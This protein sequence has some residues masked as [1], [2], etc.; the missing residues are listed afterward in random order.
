MNTLAAPSASTIIT[1]AK[2]MSSWSEVIG[3]LAELGSDR[4]LRRNCRRGQAE[5]GERQGEH[6][7]KREFDH[8]RASSNIRV[9]LC[10]PAIERPRKAAFSC[11]SESAGG[12]QRCMMA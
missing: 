8:G 2:R 1:A 9:A 11:R 7:N 4:A 3:A 10:D 5:C 12:G 6:H